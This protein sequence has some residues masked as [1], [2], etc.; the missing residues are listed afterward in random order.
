MILS[1]DGDGM[2]FGR[3]VVKSEDL[4]SVAGRLVVVKALLAMTRNRTRHP[5]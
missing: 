3:S 1:L 2:V 4:T 5:P